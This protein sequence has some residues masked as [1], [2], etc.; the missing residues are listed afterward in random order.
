MENQ[1][2]LRHGIGALLLIEI[3]RLQFL[4]NLF[5]FLYLIE[6]D[7]IIKDLPLFAIL[8]HN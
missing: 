5:F 7:H 2:L 8:I 1:K 6:I 4:F 3:L